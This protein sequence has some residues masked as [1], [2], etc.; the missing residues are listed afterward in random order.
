MKLQLEEIAECHLRVALIKEAEKSGSQKFIKESSFLFRKFFV[1][2]KTNVFK[3][4]GK[5]SHKL[6]LDN[7]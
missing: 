1:Y 6:L 5:V 3:F 4:K 7:I 2:I